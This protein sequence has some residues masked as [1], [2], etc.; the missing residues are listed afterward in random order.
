MSGN[1][2]VVY[3]GTGR[4]AIEDISY[5]DLILRDG[6]GVNPLNVGR[7]CDHGVILKVVTTNICGSDQH[8]VRGRTTAPEGLVLGHEITG[9]VIEVGRDVEFIK[10][11]DLVSVP[12]N[13]ACGRCRSCKERNT[14]ICENVNPDRP[15]SAYGYVDM[16][17]WVGG[18]SEYVMVPYADFQLLKFP[19]K[20]QALEKILDLTM[21]SDI[22]P[23][24]YHG[25]VS[26]GVKPGA[27]VYVA[28]AGPVGLAAA[29]SAQLLGAS[30]VI[31]GDLNSERL[32]QAKSFGCETVNLREH[33]NL[34]EQIE[35]I[36]GVPEVDCA[37][38]CVGFEA[39]GHGA[40]AGEA[41]ATVLNSIMEVTRA[42]GR[43][44]IP[45][46]YVTGDPGA[47]DEDAKIG[48]LKVRLG[49]GWAK[50]HTFV[51]GQTPVMQYHRD[52]M[53]A[54]LSGKAQIA[55]AVNAT[56]IPL[57]QAPAAYAEFDQ[58]A[59]K[60]FVIDPHGLVRK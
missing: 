54:I 30:V 6:P 15:G 50:A 51:T 5:P 20:D 12:F 55:K 35:Q 1:R 31:V 11:G 40:S 22:F 45:G 59:S 7:K 2:A 38:D 14:H 26:A 42:G 37:V 32:A 52:L 8:M 57:D 21:L 24:G 28:G 13:I 46:L 25:A 47:V 58:G 33:T 4:V 60:K 53:K 36:L 10:K 39:H 23:T 27:T 44:G 3:K 17:G 18:Q 49:L 19:D 41:P 29:H 56:L 48:T 34:G 43:L 16:G 9:E